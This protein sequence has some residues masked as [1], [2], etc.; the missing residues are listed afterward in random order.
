MTPPTGTFYDFGGT[1]LTFGRLLGQGGEG[2]VYEVA[3]RPDTVAKLYLKPA[4][5]EQADKL[6]EMVRRQDAEL[7]G[8]TAWPTEGI[9]KGR[10]GPVQGFLMPNLPGYKKL[11]SLYINSLR[12]RH[13]PQ[14]NW[15]F[16]VHAARNTAA[17]F[18]AIHAHGY[19]VGDVNEENILVS[20]N[21]TVKLIDCDSFQV[22]AS[23]RQF[24]CP[25][26][27]PFFVPPELQGTSFRNTPRTEDHD[28]FGMAVLCFYLLFLGLH[29]FKGRMQ[30]KSELKIHEAIEQCLFPYAPAAVFRGL[31]PPPGAPPFGMLPAAVADLFEVAF[32]EWGRD[33]GR[34][35]A[36]EWV[37]ALDNLEQQLVVC[38]RTP[39][40]R[41]PPAAVACPWCE[42]ES[43][44]MPPLFSG[45]AG[46]SGRRTAPPP[47]GPSTSGA[48][49]RSGTPPPSVL[50]SLDAGKK[51]VERAWQGILN[52]SSPGSGQLGKPALPRLTPLSVPLWLRPLLSQQAAAGIIAAFCLIALFT[53]ISARSLVGALAVGSVFVAVTVF[54]R[55]LL[56]LSFDGLPAERDRRR[57]RLAQVRQALDDLQKQWR[58]WGDDAE[59]QRV[60]Q[61]LH[62][63][64]QHY[65]QADAALRQVYLRGSIQASGQ[66]AALQQLEAQILAGEQ[67][68]SDIKNR[69]LQERKRIR[70]EFARLTVQHE[71]ARIDLQVILRI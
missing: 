28:L 35:P 45:G 63:A 52:V 14:A 67:R 51:A 62:Q 57:Q 61:R 53:G 37:K 7:L 12:C 64:Y 54:T 18:A 3:G 23:G 65:G 55:L 11:P 4:S 24:L 16:I 71:Q 48:S 15:K 26:A 6:R 43:R 60:R 44:G 69:T 41:Y 30:G 58:Q 34:P 59:F 1:P 13:F 10:N 25:V 42:L 36:R 33:H 21:A 70:R 39:D 40:H 17:A 31:R 8:F 68:L 19:I 29:P 32:G 5:S 46:K 20:Q 66:Q 47:G 49:P 27:R 22:T 50:H 38:Q 2:E 9:T 56:F